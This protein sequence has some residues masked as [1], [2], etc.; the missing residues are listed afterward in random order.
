VIPVTIFSVLYNLPK[1][2]ELS[3]DIVIVNP[4]DPDTCEKDLSVNL[5][6]VNLE[7]TW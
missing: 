4:I 3:T 1:F 6:F 5:T 2:F 7:P